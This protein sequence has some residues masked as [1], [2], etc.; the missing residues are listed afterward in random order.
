M[1]TYL[2]AEYKH[3][4]LPDRLQEPFFKLTGTAN[5]ALSGL[6][7]S[8]CDGA[9]Y[10]MTQF[11]WSKVTSVGDSSAYVG[12]LTRVLR[13]AFSIVRRRLDETP[14]RSFC[15]KFVR[16]FVPRYVEAVYRCK[17]IGEMGAQQL[18]LDV[19]AVKAVLLSLPL[20]KPASD[21]VLSAIAGGTAL[22]EGEEEEG[23]VGGRRGSRKPLSPQC[24]QSLS[25][26]SCQEWK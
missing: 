4:V 20:C 22:P 3:L 25:T 14:F 2:D 23:G 1:K 24:T 21:K 16:A 5:A 6:V 9:L 15:D 11:Q 26:R 18:L 13:R 10:K 17:K 19:T 8:L 12:E 7:S